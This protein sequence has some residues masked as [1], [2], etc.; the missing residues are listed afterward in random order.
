MPAQGNALIITHIFGSFYQRAIR[1]GVAQ[2][3]A[4]VEVRGAVVAGSAVCIVFAFARV[5]AHRK[6]RNGAEQ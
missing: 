4:R 5:E 6:S 3:V 2:V 1:A